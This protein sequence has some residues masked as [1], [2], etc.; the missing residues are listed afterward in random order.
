MNDSLKK[1]NLGC[2]SDL[3]LSS[4]HKGGDGYS[5]VLARTHACMYIHAYM[6]NMLKCAHMHTDTH[7]LKTTLI[8]A[9]TCLCT[10]TY[11]QPMLTDMH[12]H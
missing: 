1:P 2:S 6:H 9:Y 3:S 11:I 10:H 5:H 12:I 4:S 7:M 8:N